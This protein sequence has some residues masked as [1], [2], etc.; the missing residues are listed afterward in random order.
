MEAIRLG[1][2]GSG[3]IVH[4]VLD[5][6]KTAGGITLEAVYSRTR[7]KA[8]SLAENIT[9]RKFTRTSTRL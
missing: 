3:V 5:N 7:D 1:T 9:L 4:S 6:V 8:E 2:I